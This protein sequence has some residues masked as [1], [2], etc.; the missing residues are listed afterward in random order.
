MSLSFFCAQDS[1]VQLKYWL[2]EVRNRGKDNVVKFIVGNK[3]DM[4]DAHV[5]ELEA[6]Q[7]CYLLIRVH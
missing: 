7:V 5:V 4:D 6:A 1:F 2:E 3:T